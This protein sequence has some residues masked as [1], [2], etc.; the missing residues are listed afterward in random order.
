[1]SAGNYRFVLP[2]PNSELL[3][4]ENMVQNDGY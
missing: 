1:L 4:N 3:A 2:I